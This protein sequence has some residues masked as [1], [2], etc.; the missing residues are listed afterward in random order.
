MV[1]PV[2]RVL[3]FVFLLILA[4]VVV[5]GAIRLSRAGLFGFSTDT[6]V[7]TVVALMAA[8][9]V[10]VSLKGALEAHTN[11]GYAILWC[12]R[13][14]ES[15]A[16]AGH[17]NRWNEAILADACRGLALPVTLSDSSVPGSR[18]VLRHSGGPLITPLLIVGISLF[19]W[20][21]VSLPD[22]FVDSVP[23]FSALLIAYGLVWFLAIK[24]MDWVV[25]SFASYRHSPERVAA[26]LRRALQRRRSRSETL[27]VRCTSEDWRDNVLALLREVSFVVLDVTGSSPN[28][29]WEIEQS[30]EAPGAARVLFLEEAPGE[31]EVRLE[32]AAAPLLPAAGPNDD[33]TTTC[34]FLRYSAQRAASERRDSPERANGDDETS[35]RDLL[36]PHA[37]EISGA[38]RDWMEA[39]RGSASH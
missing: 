13:F 20:L 21:V 23:G 24:L 7:I 15:D 26:K 22:R 38:L 34:S 33:S 6:S 5:V 19:L 8:F 1:L 27:V 35:G 16:I 17:R 29:V 4:L 31:R 9:G 39:N 12:R 36:G 37:L 25:N 28:V 18:S 3:T 11:E 32:R 2:R 14:G 10:A 30:L